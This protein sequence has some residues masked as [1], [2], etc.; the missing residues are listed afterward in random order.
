MALLPRMWTEMLG[1]LILIFENN[2]PVIGE[3]V[4]S[5]TSPGG[6]LRRAVIIMGIPVS[7]AASS[8]I[9]TY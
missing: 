3:T 5:R 7:L 9:C 6:R 1:T 4:F 8:P 2:N